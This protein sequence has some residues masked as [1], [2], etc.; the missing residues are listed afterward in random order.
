MSSGY[1]ID[2]LVDVNGKTIGVE[3]DGRKSRSPLGRTILKRSQVPA[4]DEIDLVSVPYWEWNKHGKS[5]SK[6][7]EYL[8]KLFR[9]GRRQ[10]HDSNTLIT[11]LCEQVRV[12]RL[13]MSQHM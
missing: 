7:Q 4:I 6:K 5:Q 12:M 8:Q 11:Y 3:V 1:R 2:A 10:Q 9:F 13:T